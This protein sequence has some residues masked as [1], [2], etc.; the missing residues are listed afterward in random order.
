MDR[1]RLLIIFGAA[2]MSALALTWFLYARTTAPKAARTVKIL[3]ATRDLPAGTQLK[4]GDLKLVAVEERDLPKAALTDPG[5]AYHRALLYPVNGNEPVTATKLSSLTGADGVAATIEPG[6]RAVSVGFTDASGASGLIQPRSRV[7]VL[8]T[9]TGS[10]GEALTATILEDVLVL[11]IG[12]TTEVQP[13]S[14]AAGASKSTPVRTQNQTATLMVTPEEARKLEFAKNQGK[15]SLALRNPL[16]RGTTAGAEPATAESL[17]PMLAGRVTRK[18][19]PRLDRKSW[20][21]LTGEEE[22][23]KPKP[24]AKKAEPP[25][26]RLVVDVYRGE[27][28]VQEIFQ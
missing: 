23:P 21:Q 14:T 2:W 17:D 24:E 5:L 15:L 4:K 19:R 3:A 25:K 18:G 10:I 7:D 28:H 20:A 12:R 16:D 27:K 26:P 6:K 8:F 22:A 13:L 1:Q 11:S 9:R